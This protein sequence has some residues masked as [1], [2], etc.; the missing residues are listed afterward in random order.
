MTVTIVVTLEG[1]LK[2]FFLVKISEVV[3][4]CVMKCHTFKQYYHN[5][6][7]Y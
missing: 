4:S 1:V 7:S 5:K 6:F 3:K 2:A